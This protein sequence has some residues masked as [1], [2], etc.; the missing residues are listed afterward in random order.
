MFIVVQVNGRNLEAHF[1]PRFIT[2]AVLVINRLDARRREHRSHQDQ[3]RRSC[4]CSDRREK[5]L[6]EHA[7]TSFHVN[8]RFTPTFPILAS[9]H[10]R[11]PTPFRLL[12]IEM[13]LSPRSHLIPP[14]KW[15][16]PLCPSKHR[17]LDKPRMNSASTCERLLYP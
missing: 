11:H 2:G 9:Q 10:Q 3:P 4:H 8:R 6:C 17:T 12:L 16:T 15:L 7:I 13:F 5:S 1:N 14:R